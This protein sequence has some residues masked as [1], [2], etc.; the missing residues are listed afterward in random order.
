MENK[1]GARLNKVY[2]LQ[3]GYGKIM[4]VLLLNILSGQYIGVDKGKQDFFNSVIPQTD[5]I[6]ELQ[7]DYSS[8]DFTRL[9]D[10]QKEL[11]HCDNNNGALVLCI[12]ERETLYRLQDVKYGFLLGPED[13]PHNEKPFSRWVTLEEFLTR[14]PRYE[15]IDIFFARIFNQMMQFFNA[16][17][18]S[19]AL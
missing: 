7:R 2:H 9:E 8:F 6:S 19:N 14:Q 10:C 3:W 4:S 18:I 17:P 13:L 12:K 15:E 11:R 1:A 16:K 5:D